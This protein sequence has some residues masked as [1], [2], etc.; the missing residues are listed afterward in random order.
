M[1]LVATVSLF[2]SLVDR[3]LIG[4]F[5]PYTL[6]LWALLIALPIAGWSE[7]QGL[8]RFVKWISSRRE[9]KKPNW[10]IGLTATS[11]CIAQGLVFV[12]NYALGL[13]FDNWVLLASVFQ[14]TLFLILES[15]LEPKSEAD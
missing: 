13:G 6:P 5:D 8:V 2:F 14:L 4:E 11:F 1:T 3:F 7:W 12:S 9:G 10:L 15:I